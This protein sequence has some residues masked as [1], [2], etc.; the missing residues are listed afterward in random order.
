MAV[1]ELLLA[2]TSP[3]R[4]DLLAAAGLRFE[5]CEP[6]PEYLTGGD[7]DHGER[8]EPLELARQRARRKA[9]GAPGQHTAPVLG[10]DTVVDLDGVE[11]GKPADRDQAARML[12]ALSG[13]RHLVHTAHC[14]RAP[15]G[16]LLGEQ[17]A[18][19]TV[20]C[21]M[22]TPAELQRYLDSEQWR[23]KAGSYGIQDDAQS[24]L[25]LAGGAFDTV[26]GLHVPAVLALLA[27]WS[28]RESS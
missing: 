19:A 3:R 23:G 15:D 6:G 7:H 2:S 27:N 26:V 9:L 18:T 21:R 8:G 28:A 4:R 13:R 24:F 11:L 16:T 20:N 22:P 10:V 1:I 5:L 17:M 14:L 12:Q 25:V